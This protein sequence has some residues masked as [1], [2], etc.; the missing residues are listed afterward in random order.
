MIEKWC[1]TCEILFNDNLIK[2]RPF[3]RPPLGNFIIIQ[4]QNLK[5]LYIRIIIFKV[6]VKYFLRKIW[7]WNLNKRHQI[8]TIF[9]KF[10]SFLLII[11]WKETFRA[12]LSPFR[13]RKNLKWLFWDK[14]IFTPRMG[15]AKISLSIVSYKSYGN[16]WKVWSFVWRRWNHLLSY[17][18][19]TF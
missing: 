1:Q 8:E 17:L 10:I 9:Y 4:K 18:S 16:E 13:K 2:E 7:D 5:I 6:N 19:L 14:V 3:L 15:N 11:N 12:F